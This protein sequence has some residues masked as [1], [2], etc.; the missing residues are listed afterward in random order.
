MLRK[1]Q[2]RTSI[3][4]RLANIRHLAL[5]MDGTVYRG[6]TLFPTTIPFLRVLENLGI[7]YT[8]LTNNP[9]KSP[10]D[11]RASLRRMGIPIKAEQ[12]YTSTQATVEFL[13]KQWPQA[14]TLFV[15][16]TPSMAQAFAGAGYVLMPDH[17]R[18]QPDAVVV[19]FD[20]TLTY[21]RLCRA[22]WWI[23]KGVPYVATN[24]D[25]VCPTDEPT[26]LVDCG[27]ITAA[28]EKA[29]GR[30]PAAVMGKPDVAMLRGILRRHS[31]PPRQLGMVGDRLYTDIAMA[32]RAGALGVLVLTGEATARDAA[33]HRP[34]PDLV[35]PSLAELGGKLMKAQKSK[36]SR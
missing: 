5:D 36:G 8:F 27:S 9:S 4:K 15:L 24:P 33:R 2:Q 25:C 19:G 26:V 13:Q 22:A 30:P 23:S 11:Y 3:L 17:P 6:G 29:T 20:T 18:K 21:L 16:G 32:Q 31:L 14:R 12:L 7:G 28:L 34:R 1:V 35:V 10:D